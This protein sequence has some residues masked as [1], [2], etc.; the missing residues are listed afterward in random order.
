MTLA[1]WITMTTTF[2]IVTFF[3]VYFFIR[4][5]KAPASHEH[6]EMATNDHTVKMKGDNS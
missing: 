4:V 5:L 6:N 2:S 1:A 3:A